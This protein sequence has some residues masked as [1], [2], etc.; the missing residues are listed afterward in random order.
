MGQGA[1]MLY[2]LNGDNYDYFTSHP[3]PP[4]KECVPQIIDII[5]LLFPRIMNPPLEKPSVFHL[6]LHGTI[7]D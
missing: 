3:D 7:S 6:I 4:G 2:V 5:A 1:L